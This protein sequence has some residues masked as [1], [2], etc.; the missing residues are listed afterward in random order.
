MIDSITAV[1]ITVSWLPGLSGGSAQTFTV[2]YR[3]EGEGKIVY[4]DGIKAME[5]NELIVYKVSG[6]DP[7]TKYYL[8]VQAKNTWGERNSL[9]VSSFTL[10]LLNYLFTKFSIKHSNSQKTCFKTLHAITN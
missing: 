4:Q 7:Q 3:K 6:L 8:K 10:G 9:E 5:N 1:S 2:Y